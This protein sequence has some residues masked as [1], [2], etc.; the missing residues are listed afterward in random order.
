G[1]TSLA[2]SVARRLREAGGQA[3]VV[4]LSQLG[5]RDG[6]TE[7]GRWYYGLAYRVLRDL[8][9]KLDLQRWWQEH[10]PLTPAQRLAEFF[11]EIV[12]GGTDGPVAVFL[13]EIE[14][15]EQAEYASEL[16]RVVRG[17]FDARAGEP[18]YRRL[19]FVLLGTAL[20]AGTA[21]RASGSVTEISAR[22]ELPDFKFEQARNLA[23]GLGL[24]P[25]D[26]ER[27]LYRVMYWTSGHPYLTQRLC[28]AIARNAGKVYSDET[29]DA[30]VGARFLG[31]NVVATESSMSR[32]LDGLD[33]AGKLARPALR[34]YRRI[35]RGRRVRY[36]PDNPRHELLRVCGLAKLGADRRLVVRNRIYAEAFSGR[37]ARE[38]LP[39]EWGRIGRVAAVL[40]VV[41]GAGWGYLEVLPR[42]YE[43]TLRVVSVE[44]EEAASAWQ[45]LGRL[46]GF[47]AKA[48]RLFARVLIRRSRLA[49]DWAVVAE[50]DALLRALRGYE[51][52]ADALQVEFWERRAAAAEA[53]ERRAEALLYRLR[54][55][56]AG[57][58]A[59]AGRA[60]ALSGGDYAQLLTVIRTAAP[61]EAM[62]MDSAN[63]ALVT[64]SGD[65]VLQR[66][67]GDSGV[68]SGR[69]EL[70][71]V[72]FLPVVRRVGIDT[73]GR[74]GRARLELLLEHEEPGRLQARLTAPS[75]RTVTLPVAAGAQA[76]DYLLLG[77]E[78]APVLRA[79][80][81]EDVLGTWT[82]ELE[83]RRPGNPGTLVAWRLR[84]AD[85]GVPAAED[86][87]ENPLLIEPPGRTEVVHAALA[88][89]GARVAATPANAAAGGRLEAWDTRTGATLFTLDLE[90]GAR[91]LAFVGDRALLLLEADGS[92]Q[93][94]R[95]LAADSGAEIFSQEYAVPLR[96]GPAAAPDGRFL[97]TVETEPRA[98]RVYEVDAG[99]ETFALELTGEATAVAV[100]PGGLL[101]AVA[102]RDGFIRVWHATDGALAAELQPGAPVSG[103]AFDP[104]GRWLVAVDDAGRLQAWDL[105]IA[106]PGPVLIRP[107]SGGRFSLAA[108]GNRLLAMDAGRGLE[109]WDLGAGAA[110]APVLRGGGASAVAGTGA[111]GSA[112]AL[113]TEDGRLVSGQGTRVLHIWRPAPT[114]DA[115]A[116]PR[117]PRVAA[118]APSGLRAAAGT[119]DGRVVL[120][121]RDPE[122]LRLRLA[123]LTSVETRHGGGVAALA[124]AAAGQR[125]ASAGGDGTVLLWDA[126]SGSLRGS[127]LQHG[128]GALT[129][130]ALAGDGR[131]LV[132]TGLRG[133]RIWDAETG[134]PGPMLGPGRAVSAVALDGS[135][136][137]VF[138]ATPAG[139]VERWDV[140]GG[141]RLWFAA[142]E[143]PVDQLAVTPDG[144]R[145]AAAG[146]T[147][148]VGAWGFGAAGRLATVALEAPVLDLK[149]SP[150]GE[151]LLAQTAGWLH[152]LGVREGRLEVLSSRM[153]PASV[154][155]GAW[156][157]ANPAGTR[158]AVVGG[159]RAE[160]MAVLDFERVAPP[161][162]EWR[163]VLETWR[164]RLK[165]DFDDQGRLV[166]ALPDENRPQ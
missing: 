81:G 48:D 98:A 44:L 108:G 57:P 89:G 25:G 115:M 142:L 110:L 146:P 111:P 144:S 102:D 135:G 125:L 15:V 43:D 104:A 162:E 103:L 21:A 131:T 71:A 7:V 155:P 85:A 31:R 141:E 53:I 76:G 46:P 17:C 88:P 109:F 74:V 132:T 101:L 96:A 29:V 60:A 150:D 153:L 112:Y 82:L 28:Q 5:S 38:A 129:G 68:A 45:A 120:R 56:E 47:G 69:Q 166:P 136:E 161:A 3:A 158:V 12:I 93:R 30:L 117:L 165:L 121:M 63:G 54:A 97:A 42:P 20:P 18:E 164:Q 55:Y 59:D 37:W 80:R 123:T 163:P 78:Q 160:A 95:V 50:S 128:L 92:G 11:W 49:D 67:D 79:L 73:A 127:P 77:E 24:P 52:R 72:E 90:P 41:A 116:L 75:G 100:A 137:R 14:S 26:A 62:A 143:A 159:A 130:L 99:R 105:A 86:R 133:A 134:T 8:R 113:M 118:L 139:L 27:A 66:W 9:L 154:A 83:D 84:L 65:N 61:V 32:V 157:N 145:V 122:S 1:K 87:P 2:A 151:A 119:S 16:F 106:E 91:R 70:L 156:R 34:L 40:A 36:Q 94:L 147:G 51:A 124:F 64:L 138:L 23:P 152:R 35:H 107:D 10:L 33:R 22:I 13:D 4:D 58:T 148:Q 19:G 114:A 6:S 140:S 149:F 39:L 126:R